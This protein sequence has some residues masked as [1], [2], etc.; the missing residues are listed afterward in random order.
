MTIPQHRGTAAVFEFVWVYIPP[1]LAFMINV[2]H[3]PQDERE[4]ISL[5]VPAYATAVSASFL[6]QL[7]LAAKPVRGLLGRI[8]ISDGTT[9][10]LQ[11]SAKGPFC[12]LEWP[13][14]SA[15]W[16]YSPSQ[17]YRSCT[18]MKPRVAKD[19]FSVYLICTHRSWPFSP[20]I[21]QSRAIKPQYIPVDPLNPMTVPNPEQTASMFSFAFYFFLDHIIFRAYRE[22]QLQKNLTLSVMRHRCVCTSKKPKLQVLGQLFW[23]YIEPSYF[24][25]ID[26]R[27]SP[28]IHDLGGS[29]SFES[30]HN[31]VWVT[32][33]ITTWTGSSGA[34]FMQTLCHATI[35]ANQEGI[36]PVVRPWVWI[37]LMFFSSLI[38]KVA[39]SAN[40]PKLT[41]IFTGS[42]MY[43]ICDFINS[44][45]NR[46]YS[47]T[48]V[49]T[50][51]LRIRMKAET[52]DSSG[53]ESPP[54]SESDAD[55]TYAVS[56]LENSEHSSH[57]EEETATVQASTSSIKSTGS[58][59]SSMDTKKLGR[60][61]VG[62]ITNL[63]TTD[64]GNIVDSRE[65]LNLLIFIPLQLTL[66][67]WFLYGPLG[68][69]VW[70]GVA[71][72]V[73]LAP[74]PGYMAKLVQSVQKERLKRTD[75]RVQ[76]VS[77][78]KIKL[79]GWEEKTKAR[80]ADE[81]GWKD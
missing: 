4:N 48:L 67:I 62:K 29:S 34:N 58:R 60:S 22:S 8:G 18:I 19:C 9:R 41:W 47:H 65:S 69:S 76:S 2:V 75:D 12:G 15:V 30:F 70:V 26:A 55:S 57:S 20:S 11:E 42:I 68:W 52:T 64:L 80:I 43:Q 44:C 73:V 7:V 46:G 32:V 59:Q 74:M 28:R 23:G 78:V 71:S 14:C 36:V 77:E 33:W 31:F 37:A 49:F 5:S 13:G 6:L 72:I 39:A 27:L 51:S 63:V 50:H 21:A 79:F 40:G 45:S 3:L 56:T 1:Q 16:A 35:T 25:R 17:S 38:G 10:L 81:Y 53:I 24:L 66:G 61:L 54:L